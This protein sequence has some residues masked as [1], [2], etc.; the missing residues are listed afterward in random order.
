MTAV[1]KNSETKQII[2]FFRTTYKWLQFHMAHYWDSG[3]QNY[4]NE[5]KSVVELG[6]TDLLSVYE[7][8]F[9]KMPISQETIKRL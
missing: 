8:S 9:A 3:F 6:H 5:K 4:Q 7:S 1:T 2:F